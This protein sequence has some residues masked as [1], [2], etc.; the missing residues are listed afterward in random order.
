MIDFE[1]KSISPMLI[2]ADGEAFDSPDYIYELKW[3][4]ERCLA[5]LDPDTGTELRNKRN[6]K[7]LPKVPEL[8]ALHQ[9]VNARCILDG[10]LMVLKNGRP[11]YYEIQKRS[12]MSNHFKIELLSKKYP[13]SFIPFDILYYQGR[14]ITLLPLMERKKYLSEAIKKETDRMAISKWIEAQGIS[15][16]NLAKQQNLEGIVAKRKDSIYVAGK[17]TKDWIK[18]KNLKDEDFVVCGYIYKENN[19]ISIVLG[20]YDGT[21]LVY[22]GHVT[23][24]VGGANFRKIEETAKV[25]SPDFIPPAGNEEAVWVNPNLV[26]TVKFMDYTASG[27]MR[28]PVFKGLREDK[29]PKDCQVRQSQPETLR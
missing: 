10:E 29:V 14:D 26:C 13:A 15:F 4:G 19:M 1:K 3:D 21:E 24:G 6:L 5:Y 12:I 20:Q 7:M 22:K 9:Q 27:G 17:R 11:D 16:Y 18:M 28:Q 8:S 25:S 2:G 23:L